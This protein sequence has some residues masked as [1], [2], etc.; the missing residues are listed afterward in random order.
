MASKDKAARAS[1]LR[2]LQIS[3]A[4]AGFRT[5]LAL[6]VPSISGNPQVGQTLTGVHADYAAPNTSYAYRWLYNGSAISLATSQTYVVQA[7]QLGGV[8]TFEE[9]PTNSVG[10][11]AAVVSSGVTI[12]AA[13]PTL[14]TLALS[15]SSATA[16]TSATINITG[17]TTGSVIAGTVPDG[18]TLNSAARTITGTP[19]LAGVYN[20]SLT[21]TLAGAI[22]SPKTTNVTMYP[23]FDAAAQSDGTNTIQRQRISHFN[24][25]EQLLQKVRL[26]YVG[27]TLS[28]SEADGPNAIRV[29]CSIEYPAGTFTQCFDSGSAALTTVAADG[30]P[31]AMTTGS[32]V[33]IPP[34]AQFWERVEVIVSSGQKWCNA[35]YVNTSLGEAVERDTTT[36]TDKTMGGTYTNAGTSGPTALMFGAA[37]IQG[38]M[39]YAPPLRVALFGDS[40]MAGR[41]DSAID[42]RG[43]YGWPARAISGVAP[44]LWMG[45]SS[46]SLSVNVANISRRMALLQ[47]VGVNAVH[48]EWAVNDLRAPRTEAQI[49]ANIATLKA[50]LDAS[51]MALILNTATPS[52][53]QVSTLPPVGS[54]QS[55]YN[56]GFAAG[57]TSERGKFNANV[58]AGV[59]GNVAY[60]EA[61]DAVETGRDTGLWAGVWSGLASDTTADLLHPLTF[62]HTAI[63]ANATPVWQ[64]R[65]GTPRVPGVITAPAISGT[66]QVGYTLSVSNGVWSFTPSSYAYQWKADGTNISGATG[67]TYN[68]V[69]GDI[70]KAITCQVTATNAGGSTA[71]TTAATAAVAAAASNEAETTALLAAMTVQ[72]TTGRATLINDLIKGLKTDGVWAKLKAMQIYA[73]HA[74]Q[75][76]QLD[77]ITATQ[78]AT[79]VNAPTYTVDRGYDLVVASSQYINTGVNTST[80]SGVSQNSLSHGLWPRSGTTTGAMSGLVGA[81]GRI[82]FTKSGSGGITAACNDAAATQLA[83]PGT[84]APRNAH[85]AIVRSGASA[86]A[87]YNNASLIAS[88][89]TASNGVQSGNHCIGISNATY[90]DANPF[91]W[92]VADGTMTQADITAIHNR[93]ST[94]KTALGA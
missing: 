70:G 82:I 47:A 81:S 4:L 36:T 26:F 23:G 7:G 57:S 85:H 2:A 16:G 71:A 54:D 83:A 88:L 37:A 87:Y 51:G 5:P 46:S 9:T 74:E 42:S 59:Y 92:W 18:M 22:G 19:T 65:K 30:T 28:L 29:R 34:G 15:S 61:A 52:T 43:H 10:A 66:A 21:E 72:P 40:I 62:G 80:L 89:T 20:F 11:G 91:V 25:S 55:P 14:A 78:K 86:T 32:N 27:S 75:A 64:A 31:V 94:Y 3:E 39:Q 17:A 76:G 68:P 56:S 73:A 8:I 63:V 13:S 44:F 93:L 79:V 67:S 6:G 49:A 84:A 41:G 69:V 77:W 45:V 50:L 12:V 38:L 24:D 33:N 58:R 48:A 35:P 53:T 60:L 90:T 1:A